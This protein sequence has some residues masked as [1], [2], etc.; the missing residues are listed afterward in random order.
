M[1][2]TD[3]ASAAQYGLPTASL[4]PS[5]EDGPNPTFS[6]SAPTFVAPDMAGILAG[7]KAMTDASVPGVLQPS[8]TSQARGAYPLPML[9]YA[10]VTPVV[11]DPTAKTNYANFIKFAVG[12]GQTPGLT[13]G[14]LPLGYVPL[15]KALV[16]QAD[17]AVKA[18]LASPTKTASQ[19]TPAGSTNPEEATGSAPAVA[20]SGASPGSAGS[21]SVSS[22]PTATGASGTTSPTSRGLSRISGS[23]RS[24][25]GRVT[26]ASTPTP[27]VVVGLIRYLVVAMLAIGVAAA[28]V[29]RWMTLRR[30]RP[31]T[32]EPQS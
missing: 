32:R 24:A 23:S 30:S 4:S 16:T 2:V 13:F 18:I 8:V 28:F 21:G 29:A 17:E 6:S 9:T 22:G 25:T 7:E 5:G 11:L 12:P 1:S 15:P 10:A 31:S 26:L 19:E 20:V 3:S 14:D 27:A